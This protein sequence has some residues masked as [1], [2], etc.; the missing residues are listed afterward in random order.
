MEFSA[1][2]DVSLAET[3]VCVVDEKGIVIMTGSVATEPKVLAD[4]LQPYAARLRR[5]GHEAGS[6]SPWLH[7]GLQAL[8][9][10]VVCLAVTVPALPQCSQNSPS[11]SAEDCTA[12]QNSRSEWSGVLRRTT[13]W[14]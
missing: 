7:A 10:P 8:G 9:L 13:E 12:H 14:I 6:L 3:S 2:L 11:M 5:V 4:L 1:E